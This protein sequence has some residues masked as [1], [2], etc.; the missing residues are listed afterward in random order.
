MNLDH[1]TGRIDGEITAGQFKNRTLSELSFDEILQF[2][3]VCERQ[4]PEALRLLQAFIE[5]E[6]PEQWKK[7]GKQN[8]SSTPP[9]DEAMSVSEAW[10][11]LGLSPGADQTAIIAAHKKLM[12]R[13]HP[14]KGGSNFLASR[15]NL[16]KDRLIAEIQQQ[17]GSGS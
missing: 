2:Y 6:F 5:R 11:T 8:A 7:T 12:G 16:A 3:T 4:D 10:E 15:V 17:N 1:A 14:D 13:L 9:S